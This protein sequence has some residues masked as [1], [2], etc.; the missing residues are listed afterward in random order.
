MRSEEKKAAVAAYKERKTAAGIYLLRCEP[1]G[2]RWVGRATDLGSIENRLRFTLR[3]RSH[4]HR[5]LQAAWDA[6]GPEAFRLEELERLDEESLAYVR[7]RLLKER[8]GHWLAKL[9]AEAI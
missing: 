6:H 9:G 7:D 3:H 2:Q 4:T 5:G 8:F 1:S